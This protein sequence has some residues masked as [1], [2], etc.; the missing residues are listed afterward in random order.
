MLKLPPRMPA[1]CWRSAYAALMFGAFNMFWTAPPLMLSGR[2][3]LGTARGRP[4]RLAGAGRALAAP[5]AGRLADLG[6]KIATTASYM[7]VIA[8]AFGA[9]GL[10]VAGAALLPLVVAT[11]LLDDAVQTN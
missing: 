2:F 7:L 11:V 10:A 5:F 4:L 3:G 1:L 9:T 8:A 6:L